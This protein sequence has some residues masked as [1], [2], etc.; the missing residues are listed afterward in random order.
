MTELHFFQALQKAMDDQAC[1]IY[2]MFHFSRSDGYRLRLGEVTLTELNFY[3]LRNYWMRGVYINTDEPDEPTTGADWDWLIGFEDTWVQIRVQAKI[4]NRQGSFAELGHPERSGEQMNTLI[5]PAAGST[6]CRW[7]PIY[8]F[9]AA[10]P[11]APFF[12]AQVATGDKRYGCSTQHARRVQDT[13]RPPTANRANLRSA[14]HLPGSVPWSSVFDGL[15]R[16]LSD[17]E[18]LRTVIQS[19]AGRILPDRVDTLDAFWDPSVTA[20]YCEVDQPD[21]LREILDRRDDGFTDA[22]L[23]VLNVNTPKGALSKASKNRIK[24]EHDPVALSAHA[25]FDLPNEFTEPSPM[26]T[27]DYT[28]RDPLQVESLP[29]LVSIVDIDRLP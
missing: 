1:A 6:Y 20:G 17:G 28:K 24:R 13:Y 8:V 29:R 7:M 18:S 22:K 26:R 19:L 5:N 10:A 25:P 21:Y 9:Y 2:D 16:R 15:V 27:L 23:S 12:N 4:I 3:S 11:P 14:S